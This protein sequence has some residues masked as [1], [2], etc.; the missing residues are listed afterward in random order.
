MLL[1]SLLTLSNLAATTASLVHN[2]AANTCCD[3]DRDDAAGGQGM[4][5]CP[6]PE[7]SCASCMTIDLITLPIVQRSGGVTTLYAQL[8]RTVHLSPCL[9]S[10]DYPPEFT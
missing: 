9:R 10:I 5:S 7:C 1:L 2:E 8:Q 6:L 4:P 3:L